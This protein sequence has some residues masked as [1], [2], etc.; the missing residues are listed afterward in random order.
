MTQSLIYVDY[1]IFKS[2]D[3]V[4]AVKNYLE[5]FSVLSY[6]SFLLIFIIY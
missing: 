4:V 1:N 2:Y 5:M 3:V 6:R